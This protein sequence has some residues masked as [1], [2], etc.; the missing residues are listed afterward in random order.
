MFTFLTNANRYKLFNSDPQHIGYYPDSQVQ[1]FII[2]T[3]FSRG[4]D[5]TVKYEK[6]RFYFTAYYCKPAGF[7]PTEF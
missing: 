4:F 7:F 6:N 1:D 3:G 2:E 5:M